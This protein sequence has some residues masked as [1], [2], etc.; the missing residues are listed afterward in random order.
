MRISTN[1]LK[2]FVTLAPPLERIAD[3]LTMAGL[4]VK[5]IETRPEFHDTVFEVEITTNRPD[6]LSHL[7]VAREI[8]AVE[9]TGLKLPPAENP[10]PRP[11]P[12]GWKLELKEGEG[13]PYYTACLIEGAEMGETP[14]WMKHRLLACGL[15]SI[16]LFVDITNY[17]LLEVGQPLHAFDADLLRG[18]E[19]QIR[20]GRPQETLVAIDGTAYTLGSEDLVIAD[21]ERAVAIAG[22]MG[23]R[24]TE[25]SERSRNV[26]LESAFFHPRWVRKSAVRLGLSSESSYRFERR[27]DPEGVD[28][29]R[30]RA[31]RLFR[32]LAGARSASAVLKAGRKPGLAK[33]RIH[34]S[35]E[36]VKK[37]LGTEI[38]P[39]QVHSVLTRL[40]LDP[41]NENRETWGVG[42]PSYRPDL[43]RPVDLV[44][45]IARIVSYEAIP[46]VLPERPPLDFPPHPLRDLQ[47]RTQDYFAGIGLSETVTFSLVNPRFFE[48][49]N[50]DLKSAVQ[51]HNPIH[52]ELT[53]LR[54]SFLASLLE[55]TGR[56]ERSG[57]RSIAIF[58]VANLYS[59]KS[60][61]EPPQESGS[62]GVILS[63]EHEAGWSDTKRP[64]SFFDLKGMLE[65]YFEFLGITNFSFL[66]AEISFL[67][68]SARI[69]VG[70]EAV[71]ILGEVASPAK[72]LWDLR[73]PSLFAEL[74]LEKLLLHL[75]LIRKFKGIP[76]FPAVERDLSL[77][78]PE[79]FKSQEVVIEI[80]R[81][82][83]GLVRR[84]TLFDL[85]RGGRI[86]PGR[87]NLAFRVTYQSA[88]R[89]LLSEEIQKLHTEIAESLAKKFGAGFQAGD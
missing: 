22:V 67:E 18:K 11:M 16:N 45:E 63:G 55:V 74:S 78:V 26:L 28:L 47:E 56:N 86:P 23:G 71:G 57:E 1:W 70:K 43:E 38:K 3:R 75:P 10:G 69:L 24:E 89:T 29:G 88:E 59:R 32:E 50:I 82:G 42:I 49:L 17:V 21:R 30:E 60:R 12:S 51:I 65:G 34:L 36:Q 61:G 68:T 8:R 52:Q 80:E 76:R 84:V 83:R 14:D 20:R 66:P 79:S 73:F 48:S 6:W 72:A 35:L 27:V 58:E 5:R 4:E 31:V 81:L 46:E 64:F 40:G 44:E 53:L 33:S 25:V 7:G 87:K 54:P 41:K 39:H 85:F 37:I 19:I 77:V 62:L 2:E 13:C 9:N 15:R